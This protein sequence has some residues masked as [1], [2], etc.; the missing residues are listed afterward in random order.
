MLNKVLVSLSL[1]SFG[2]QAADDFPVA[3]AFV[4]FLYKKL[5]EVASHG[6]SDFRITQD[7]RDPKQGYVI[8]GDGVTPVSGL[9]LRTYGGVPDKIIGQFGSWTRFIGGCCYD[10]CGGNMEKALQDML[11]K[12]GVAFTVAELRE[13]NHYVEEPCLRV[14]GCEYTI[15]RFPGV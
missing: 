15:T 2:L 1:I 9:K 6:I 10:N 7:A 5:P 14:V 13:Q 8:K 4:N 11:I 3:Q 12:A